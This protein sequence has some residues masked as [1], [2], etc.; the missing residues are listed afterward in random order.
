MGLRLVVLDLLSAK[1]RQ[2]SVVTW[3]FARPY[4]YQQYYRA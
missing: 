4:N 2:L 3:T 1:K